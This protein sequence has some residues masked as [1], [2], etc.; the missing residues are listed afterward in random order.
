MNYEFILTE[1]K[2]AVTI[3]TLNKP[4]A[5]NAL[6]SKVLDELIDAFAAFEAD[7]SQGCAILT[8]SGDKAFAAGADILLKMD[9]P[10]RKGRAQAMDRGC[11]RLF[12]R[13][14]VRAGDDGRFHYRI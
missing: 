5:L 7:S 13:R 8:G 4:K 9:Q 1:Q 14:R 6:D 12:T 2:G 3:I 11:Q 10:Y